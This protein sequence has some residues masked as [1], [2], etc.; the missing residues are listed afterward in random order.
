M[1]KINHEIPGTQLNKDA[2]NIR[3]A[4]HASLH[5]CPNGVPEEIKKTY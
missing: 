4:L 5:A 1:A 3:I 2:L